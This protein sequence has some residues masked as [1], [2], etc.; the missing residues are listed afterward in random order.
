MNTTK[1]IALFN[2]KG[3]VSKTTTTFHLGWM[4]DQKGHRVMIVD[5]DPQCNLTGVCVSDIEGIYNSGISNIK[6]ILSP[7]FDAKPE[8]L[9]AAKCYEFSGN[10][11]LFLLPGHVDFSEYDTTYNVAESLT[12]SMALFQNVPGA[13]RYVLELTAKQYDLDYILLDMSPSISATNANILMQSDY[14]FIP[15]APDYFC[16]MAIQSLSKTFPKWRNT[17]QQLMQH[18]VFKNA[19]Y[20]LKDTPPIFIGTI[21]QRY[22]PRNGSPAKAFA[23]WIESINNLV[24]KM[25]VPTLQD[26]DM[27]ITDDKK[28][29]FI[30][31]YNLANIADFNS[32]IAQSQE[33]KVPVF[34][35]TQDQVGKIGN[36]WENMKKNR[37]AFYSTFDTLADKIVKITS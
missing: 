29:C 31:P 27:C 30:E 14:F 33:H 24:S 28:D 26:I 23:E 37:D 8:P 13:L 11:N 12:G 5:T 9:Q 19:V 3:G 21:Q 25:L 35:L 34:L 7:V 6:S 10:Q 22:R 18:D 2:H 36:V 1:S 32:L 17:Y 20:R 15:C 16:Y 4:L